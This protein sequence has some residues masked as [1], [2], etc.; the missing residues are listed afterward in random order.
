V[1]TAER[2]DARNLF[3]AGGGV[4]RSASEGCEDIREQLRLDIAPVGR[5]PACAATYPNRCITPVSSTRMRRL[6]LCRSV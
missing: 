1:P 2:P 5:T 4:E 6:R 3:V